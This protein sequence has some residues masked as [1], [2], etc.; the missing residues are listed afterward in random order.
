M[1]I[2]RFSLHGDFQTW[3]DNIRQDEN[4]AWVRWKDV[5]PYLSYCEQ[6]GVEYRVTTPEENTAYII[7]IDEDLLN[8]IVQDDEEDEDI[9]PLDEGEDVYELITRKD[10]L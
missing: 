10:H 2:P 9:I 8:D 7:D 6:A 1:M 5:E 3:K 4:G